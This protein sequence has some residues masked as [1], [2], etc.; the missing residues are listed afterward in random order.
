MP[1]EKRKQLNIGISQEQYE[2]IKSAAEREGLTV[3][4]FSRDAILEAAEPQAEPGHETMAQGLPAWLAAFLI[5]LSRSG[6]ENR[7]ETA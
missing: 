3:T 5:F 2:M 7:K 1:A 4:A 6:R